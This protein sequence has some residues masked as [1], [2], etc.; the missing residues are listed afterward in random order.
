MLLMWF[1]FGAF[2]QCVV[3]FD[4]SGSREWHWRRVCP[5][6]AR[7]PHIEYEAARFEF[8]L[9][10]DRRFHCDL[11]LQR[12]Q[13]ISTA[14]SP[15]VQVENNATHHAITLLVL[16]CLASPESYLHKRKHGW[17]SSR[18]GRHD[19]LFTTVVRV[20]ARNEKHSDLFSKSIQNRA[21]AN[22]SQRTQEMCITSMLAE[23]RYR[24]RS[25]L[26][27]VFSMPSTQ[28]PSHAP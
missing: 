12:T 14:L 28:L 19:N 27:Y 5:E 23:G 4:I 18:D 22:L 3:H 20:P 17:G 24:V 13:F 2:V 11:C 7:D 8:R 21:L 1:R 10:A 25:Q 9:V 15:S 16:F 6:L 26:K